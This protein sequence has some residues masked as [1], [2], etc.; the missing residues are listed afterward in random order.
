MTML[1]KLKRRLPDAKD[2]AL[3]MDLL[4]QAKAFILSYTCRETL[5][6]PLADAQVELAAILF[7]R[8]GM[9]GEVNHG[10]GGVTRTA[11]GLP[12][13]LRRWLNP[14]RRVRTMGADG[15]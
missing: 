11:E 1:A 14:W 8:M 15:Q 3:L 12:E 6:A 9:E 2:D 7:N 5:P 4:E 13:S 10:E